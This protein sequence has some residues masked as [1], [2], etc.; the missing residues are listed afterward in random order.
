MTAQE[1]DKP[2]KYLPG[3]PEVLGIAQAQDQLFI[4]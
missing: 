2:G 4:V 3:I 1:F